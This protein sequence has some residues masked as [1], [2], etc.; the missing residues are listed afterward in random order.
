VREVLRIRDFRLLWGAQ[1]V[2]GTGSWLLVVA[3]PAHVYAESSGTVLF[4]PAVQATVS[5]VVGRGRL[6]GAATSLSALTDG[7]VRLVGPPA[8]AALLAVAGFPALVLVDVSSYLLSALAIAGMGRRRAPATAA[9][10][11]GGVLAGLVEG[12]RF[13]RRHPVARALLPLSLPFLLANALLSAVLVPFGIERLG[14][15]TQVGLVVS[16]LGV[17]FLLGALPLRLLVNRVQPRYLLAGAQ[18]GTAAGFALLFGSTG[19]ALALPAAVV[20][21]GFGSTTLAVPQTAVQ[22]TVPDPLLGRTAAVF[23]TAESLATLLGAVV[24]PALAAA[25]SVSATAVVACALTAAGALAALIAVPVGPE[26]VGG[27]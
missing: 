13:L 24:G 26:L 9:G 10:T 3:V 17:G 5:T 12:L 8:G 22:R 7:T 14:G 23:V 20:I 19:L 1:L 18:L 16:A 21:G 15:A 4:R 6:L 11:L 25:L 27:A 2:S